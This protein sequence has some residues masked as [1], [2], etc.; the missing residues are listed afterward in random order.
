LDRELKAFLAIAEE[1]SLTSAAKRVGLAQPSLTKMLRRIEAR[2]GTPLFERMA[3]GM[4]LTPAGRRF[5]ERVRRIEAEYGLALEEVAAVTNRHLEVLRIGAG[6][7]F[8]ILYLPKVLETL[9]REYPSTRIELLADTNSVILPMLE[10]GQL[11]IAVGALEVDAPY[12]GIFPLKL[13]TT[14][15]AVVHRPDHPIAGGKLDAHR[16]A[17]YRWV[18]YQHDEANVRSLENYFRSAGLPAPE[19]AMI[20][21]SFA[22]SLRVVASTDCLMLSPAPLAEAIAGSGLVMRLPPSPIRK[23]ETAI[24]LRESGREFP[25]IDRTVELLQNV[26]PQG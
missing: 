2:L 19:I 17:R 25:I 7:L 11:D 3:R 22:S 16:L 26:V 1:G 5:H 6:T 20:S 8:Q 12:H 13:G 4:R 15:M 9:V 21:T 23:F 18:I 14:E 10:Q 24:W